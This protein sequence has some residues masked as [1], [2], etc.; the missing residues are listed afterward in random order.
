MLSG[1]V[2]PRWQGAKC[3]QVRVLMSGHIPP[4]ICLKSFSGNIVIKRKTFPFL[5]SAQFSMF[6]VHRPL[7]VDKGPNGF[8]IFLTLYK[9]IIKLKSRILHDILDD[10]HIQ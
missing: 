8:F 4:M 9:R 7:K 6:F 10:D 1:F 5:L 3:C 2:Y